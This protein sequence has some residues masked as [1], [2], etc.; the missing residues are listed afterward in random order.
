MEKH[1][2]ILVG[3]NFGMYEDR[4]IDVVCTREELDVIANALKRYVYSL[5]CGCSCV[6]KE[7]DGVSHSDFD[8]MYADC[9]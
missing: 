5:G 7:G 2:Q 8:I 4:I 1:Y 9:I 3:G 6:A